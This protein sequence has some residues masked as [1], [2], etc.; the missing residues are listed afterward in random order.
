[1]VDVHIRELGSMMLSRLSRR[2]ITGIQQTSTILIPWQVFVNIVKLIKGYG[3]NITAKLKKNKE[4]SITIT[5]PTQ[6]SAMKI[7]NVKRCGRSFFIKKKVFQNINRLWICWMHQSSADSTH[8]VSFLVRNKDS[9]SLNYF[10]HTT[11]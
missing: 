5:L 8:T 9:E 1:M 6:S 3:G 2:K 11:I 4:K 7:W 10:L